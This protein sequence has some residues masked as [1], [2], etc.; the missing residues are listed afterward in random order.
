MRI[1]GNTRG[2]RGATIDASRQDGKRSLL[3]EYHGLEII[4]HVYLFFIK[5]PYIMKSDPTPLKQFSQ[6]TACRSF[7]E[8]R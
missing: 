6:G 5:L 7:L 2:R 3:N 1:E 8:E 4:T